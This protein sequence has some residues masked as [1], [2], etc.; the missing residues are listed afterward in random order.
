MAD[1]NTKIINVYTLL[2]CYRNSITI[3]NMLKFGRQGLALK[4]KG[5][6]GIS[7]PPDLCTQLIGE[8]GEGW[9]MHEARTSLCRS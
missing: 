4:I 7:E 3:G 5:G 1:A 2:F 8:L 6:G 9:G